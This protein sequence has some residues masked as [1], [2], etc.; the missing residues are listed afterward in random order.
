MITSARPLPHCLA[1]KPVEAAF[2]SPKTMPFGENQFHI[3]PPFSYRGPDVRHRCAKGFSVLVR[4]VAERMHMHM[5]MSV[6]RRGVREMLPLNRQVFGRGL[7]QEV[8]VVGN[9]DTGR[10]KGFQDADDPLPGFRIQPVGG[11]VEQQGFPAPSQGP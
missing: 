3:F 2:P 10:G 7:R 6:R 9:D 4:F 5:G 8:P 11:L 1:N